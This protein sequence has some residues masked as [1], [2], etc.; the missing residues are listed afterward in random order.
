M[1]DA[2]VQ[3]SIFWDQADKTVG[4][5]VLSNFWRKILQEEEQMVCGRQESEDSEMTRGSWLRTQ[6]GND[7]QC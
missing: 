2:V 4:G 7:T 1:M 5:R 6:A 3:A